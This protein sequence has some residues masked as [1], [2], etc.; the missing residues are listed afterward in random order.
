MKV[1]D[2]I[3]FTETGYT[4][5]VLEFTSY[6]AVSILITGDVK[7]P[8]PTL[9]GIKTVHKTAEIISERDSQSSSR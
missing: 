7:F 6:D 4:G 5:V 9:V 8:N 3:R 2:L 1:G